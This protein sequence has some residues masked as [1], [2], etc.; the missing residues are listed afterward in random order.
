MLWIIFFSQL[1]TM[2]LSTQ[3][4]LSLSFYTTGNPK[5]TQ[6]HI[7]R[8]YVTLQVNNLITPFNLDKLTNS[9]T[10]L[11][12]PLSNPQIS[13]QT[14]LLLED[15]NDRYQ[16]FVQ[17]V[18]NRQQIFK[19]ASHSNPLPCTLIMDSIYGKTTKYTENMFDLFQKLTP[20]NSETEN[21][22]D[23]NSQNSQQLI[24]S[25][26]YII[27]YLTSLH[28]L[29]E[30]EH[31]LFQQISQN[32][33]PPFF[34]T[35][36]LQSPCLLKNKFTTFKLLQTQSSVENIKMTV[37][38]TQSTPVTFLKLHPTPFFDYYLNISNSLNPAFLN[39]QLQLVTLDCSHDNIDCI[40]KPIDMSC[41]T[42]LENKNFSAIAA[43]T[44]YQAITRPILVEQ[45]LLI[46]PGA[47]ITTAMDSSPNI[48]LD[49]QTLPFI[50][51][52][53]KSVQVKYN[54]IITNFGP[55]IETGLKYIPFILTNAE[56]STLYSL[57]NDKK[58]TELSLKDFIIFGTFSAIIFILVTFMACTLQLNPYKNPNSP[59]YKPKPHK[60]TPV[61]FR[62]S[63]RS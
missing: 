15:V 11:T 27:P 44:F 13:A 19:G 41:L 39:S 53:D 26:A 40:E 38:I 59:L 56:A 43:C 4:S 1:L 7:S 14:K 18:N 3:P 54:N 28:T 12:L 22:Q 2:T 20:V 33:I 30:E 9:I 17:L 60:P 46:P 21:L 45:G 50:F 31:D 58:I 42:A 63:T 51:Q 29:L 8:T 6:K 34:Q 5:I 23:I 35:R 52:S 47:T 62:L 49:V 61:I 48:P 24:S 55:T 10:K 25:L 16:Y 32:I 57:I 36:I 37:E